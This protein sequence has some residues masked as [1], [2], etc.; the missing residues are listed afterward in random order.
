MGGLFNR[1]PQAIVPKDVAPLRGQQIDLLHSLFTGNAATNVSNFFG[2]PSD[3]QRQATGGI[4]QFLN[5]PVPEQRALDTAFP[6]LDAILNGDPSSNPT[7]QRDIAVANQSGGRFGSANA[8]MRGEA[9]GNLYK[10]R[11]QAAD[12]LGVLAS[13]AGQNPFSRLMGANAAGQ[14]DTN[15]LRQLLQALLGT[16]QSATLNLPVTQAP[17][18]WDKLSSIL[19][20]GANV[21]G[22][23]IR[24]PSR[25]PAPSTSGYGVG[26]E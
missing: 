26:Q 2:P 25:T 24:G 12:T 14:A 11:T 20:T 8:I 7:F 9:V 3:L 19:N 4:S 18:T 23:F 5:Q 22:T 21:A 16:A 13:A 10:Q 1:Q 6:S 15:S 17:S